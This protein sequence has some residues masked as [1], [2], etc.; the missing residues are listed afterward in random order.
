MSEARYHE[1][2]GR[3]LDGRI[4]EADAEEL[5]RG[6][7]T[8][9]ARLRDLR[10]HLILWELCAQ[11]QSPDRGADP[12]RQRFEARLMAEIDR[13][14]GVVADPLPWAEPGSRLFRRRVHLAC[15]AGVILA[16]TAGLLWI[17]PTA[18]PEAAD[19]RQGPVRLVSLKG[20]AVCTRCILHQTEACQL[21][22]RV[23]QSGREELWV[24]NDQGAESNLGRAYCHGATPVLAQGSLRSEHGQWSLLA[25]RLEVQH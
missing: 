16:L 18:G 25:T 7:E 2:L 15:A 11:E 10:E 19:R 21:A 1:L 6:L 22:L 14:Q 20:E 13:G 9:Q 4:S 17:R 8:D 24:V 5:R 23:H 12:F 3:M